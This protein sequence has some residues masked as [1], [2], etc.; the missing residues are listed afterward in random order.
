MLVKT[1]LVLLAILL[2]LLFAATSCVEARAPTD[3]HAESFAQLDDTAHTSL[4]TQGPDC[5]VVSPQ[6]TVTYY[7]QCPATPVGTHEYQSGG[8]AFSVLWNRH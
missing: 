2:V 5:W 8:V 7:A 4:G 1:R 6:V 3:P